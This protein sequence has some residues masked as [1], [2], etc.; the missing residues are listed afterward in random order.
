MTS[1]ARTYLGVRPHER[2]PLLY[3]ELKSQF[4]HVLLH[5]LL[6]YGELGIEFFNVSL[7]SRDIYLRL[8]FKGVHVARNIEV[9]IVFG[10]FFRSRYV[11]ELIFY[12]PRLEFAFVK[13]SVRTDDRVDIFVSKFILILSSFVPLA[14]VDEEHVSVVALSSVEDEDCRRDARSEEEVRR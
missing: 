2:T 9:E 1:R 7:H 5:F 10:D 8:F 14:R 6:N 3:C 12:C 13:F 11:G 4:F